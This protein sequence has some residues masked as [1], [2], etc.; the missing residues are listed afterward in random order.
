M[1]PVTWGVLGVSGH[2]VKRV[3]IPTRDSS[4]TKMVGIASRDAAHARAAA[5]QFGLAKSYGSYDELLKDESI[6]AVYI[7]LPNH[8]H[9]EWIKRCA[10]AGK[11]ILVEKPI[12]LNAAEAAEAVAYARQKGV[13]LMEAFMYRFHPQWQHV[14]D[15]IASGE[16][17]RVR[18]VECIFSYDNANPA[19]IRNRKDVGGGGLLDIGC[20]AVSSARFVLGRE[21]ARTV[22]LVERDPVFRTDTLASA[23]LDFGDA[24][25][26]FTVSTQ[27]QSDQRV[28]IRGTGGL[29]SVHL[30]FNVYPDVPAR[31]TVTCG[32]GTR[33]IESGPVDMYGLQFDAFSHAVRE[34][35]SAPTPPEDAVA[36]MKVLDA[37]FR[38]EQSG[39]W[40]AVL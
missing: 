19:D 29:I 15:L 8:L 23:L 2:F 30:P 25:A 7:P 17:G 36:N 5:N 34:G 28:N 31:V 14:K 32:V 10:D 3:W 27:L 20:Y 26:I 21:P 37:I 11:H 9:L 16:I 12:A 35:E 24:Q 6:E 4:V 39:A 18:N 33:N 38:S 22:A 40:E 1:K 13:L